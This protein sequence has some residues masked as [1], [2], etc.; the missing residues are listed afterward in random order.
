[1]N[2]QRMVSSLAVGL[3]V[4]GAAGVA[5]A[6]VTTD[7]S[8]S[9]SGAQGDAP[10]T[11]AVLSGDGR[12]VA[13]ESPADN[14]V[15]GDTNAVWDI[16]VRDRATGVTERV[17]VDSSG[18][19]GDAGSYDPAITP[20]GR[21]VAFRSF[22]DNL[23]PNDTNGF[24]DIF[25]HDRQTG[26]TEIVSVDSSGVQANGPSFSPSI[27]ADGRYVAFYSSA[28]NLVANDLNG[29]IDVF[30]H[31]RQTG[32]TSLVSIDSN[33]VQG[34]GDS[35]DPSISADG[36]IVAFSSTASNLIVGDTNLYSDVFA[37][38]RT[39]GTTE[40]ISQSTIGKLGNSTSDEPSISA[41]GK[42]V[43]FR[44]SATNLVPG[45]TNLAADI[46]V[47]DRVAL[48]TDIDSVDSSGNLANDNSFRPSL[49]GDGGVVAFASAASNLVA[50]DTNAVVDVFQRD[51]KKGKTTR[52]SV[53]SAGTQAN[54]VNHPPSI[55]SD[56]RQ[57]AFYSD[58]TNLVPSD[59]N[60]AT[61][62]FVHGPD[63]TLEVNPATPASG[64][65]MTF[66]TWTGAA[67]RLNMLVLNGLN[68]TPLFK[69]IL[70][71]TFDAK[72]SWTISAP[73][74]PGLAGISLSFEELG[75][76]PDGKIGVS[77]SFV[78]TFQ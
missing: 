25:V 70:T 58:A 1:M 43:A 28:T 71:A 59:T 47:R 26:T 60:A 65:L 72:G 11:S 33:W 29:F 73:T 66:L 32:V 21:F 23:V 67:G 38:D 40:L 34:N 51:R 12:Y 30:V 61:D 74:P 46:F 2:A 4:A 13:F 63:L 76:V 8:V 31:D 27:S 19:Q 68:G 17:S 20:D 54:G 6:Q 78:V 52:V 45:D 77:N 22:A 42:S 48:T 3:V 16:F 35:V 39:A 57:V 7:V 49:S 10:S 24:H 55:S 36:S 15:A 69:P 41:D 14:L 64:Q 18:V 62:C 56:A 5:T 53:D 9:S 37:R 50:N 75:F 44:S